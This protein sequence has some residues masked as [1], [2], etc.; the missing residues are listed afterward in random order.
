MEKVERFLSRKSI[1]M[2]HPMISPRGR[3]N[4]SMDF[5]KPKPRYSYN[6]QNDLV[7][8]D[9][10]KLYGRMKNNKSSNEPVKFPEIK[11]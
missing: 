9:K 11:K 2:D 6:Y 1:K 5:Q 7:R 4:H 3:I 10:N 8:F